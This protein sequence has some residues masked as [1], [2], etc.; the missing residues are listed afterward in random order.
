MKLRN[1]WVV[2]K[3]ELPDERVEGTSLFR[4]DTAYYDNVICTVVDV[5]PGRQ[6][7][8]DLIEF[9]DVKPGDKIVLDNMF[10]DERN[11]I[12]EDLYYVDIKEIECVVEGL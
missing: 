2:V 4:P 8:D 9:M 3:R 10:T 1:S 5:G 6:K 12:G 7:R 11:K